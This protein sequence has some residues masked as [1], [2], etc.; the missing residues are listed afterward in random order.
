[1]SA[2]TDQTTSVCLSGAELQRLE[3]YA[4]ARG[5]T[6]EQAATQAVSEQ[7]QARYVKP[8]ATGVVLRFP[9]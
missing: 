6:L 8:R 5:L 7:L 9:K 2:P 1:M 4:Q 3:Q